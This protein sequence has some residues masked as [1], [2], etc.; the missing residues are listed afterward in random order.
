MQV[1]IRVWRTK[2]AFRR[3]MTRRNVDGSVVSDTSD[4]GAYVLMRP[5]GQVDGF[6]P[7]MVIQSYLAHKMSM[8][9][10]PAVLDV[11]TSVCGLAVGLLARVPNASP[12]SALIIALAARGLAGDANFEIMTQLVFRGELFQYHFF[13]TVELAPLDASDSDGQV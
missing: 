2:E 13:D 3:D 12:D 4:L 1:A 7:S 6:V 8:V 10:T 9:I 5:D 11:V